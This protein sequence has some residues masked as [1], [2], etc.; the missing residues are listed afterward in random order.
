MVT[1]QMEEG[2]GVARV[3]AAARVFILLLLV[4]CNSAMADDVVRLDEKTNRCFVNGPLVQRRL[5][6]RIQP[7][8]DLRHSHFEN[9]KN[10]NFDL[11]GADLSFSI[12]SDS[13]FENARFEGLLALE[14]VVQRARFSDLSARLS[15]WRGS[16]FNQVHVDN[17]SAQSSNFSAVRILNSRIIGADLS[18]SAFDEAYIADTRFQDSILPKNIKKKAVLIN[19]TFE[20]C[21]FE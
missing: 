19:V 12:L 16:T 2:A 14:T 11:R 5:G 20:N 13:Q 18:G 1:H 4:P 21:R 7:C 9:E 10:R 8:S 3:T 6:R 15:D 17:I